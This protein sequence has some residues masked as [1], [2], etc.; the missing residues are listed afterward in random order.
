[1]TTKQEKPVRDLA[2]L[3]LQNL[4]NW[5][6]DAQPT[7]AWACRYLTTIDFERASDYLTW[8]E[9]RDKAQKKYMLWRTRALLVLFGLL[10]LGL[11][12]ASWVFYRLN[13]QAQL[14]RAKAVA[15][16]LTADRQKRLAD[17][18]AKDAQTQKHAAETNAEEAALQRDIAEKNAAAALRTARESKTR[19]LA[20]FSTESLSDDLVKTILLGMQ[21]VKATLRFGQPP[22]A[23]AD[24]A[25]HQATLTSQVRM[26]LRGHSSGVDG[27]AFSP[28]GKRLATASWDHTA[29]VWD[30]ESGKELLT[31]RGHSNGVYGVA[32][33]PD[34]KHLAT[35]SSDHTAKVWDV[36]SGRELLT[37]RGHSDSVDGVA[38]SPDGKRLAT[39]SGDHT[40]K[41]W[42]AGS[43]KE[44]LTLDGHSDVVDGVAFNPDGKRLATASWDHT[45]K[46]WDAE[47]GKELLTLRGHSDRVYG[48]AFS[49]DGKRLA[50]ASSDHTAKVWDV[51]SGKELLTL[52]DHSSGVYGVAYSPDGKRLAT[53]SSDHTAKVWD[54][55]SGKELLTL[56]GHLSGVYGVA[57]SPDGK[58]LATA[59]DDYTAKVW[60]MESGKELLTLRG[61]LSGVYGLA[62]RPDGKRLATASRDGTVQ[63]YAFDLRELLNLARSRLPAP[64]LPRTAH[65]PSSLGPAR[66]CTEQMKREIAKGLRRSQLPRVD[67]SHLE[68]IAV[69]SGFPQPAHSRAP[70]FPAILAI[71][72]LPEAQY[73]RGGTD[74]DRRGADRREATARP[75]NDPEHSYGPGRAGLWRL[76]GEV[77]KRQGVSR[78]NARSEPV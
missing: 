19:E 36:E 74:L 3:T 9:R 49:P 2:G 39:A 35:A 57:F 71:H 1:L 15:S 25:L 44:L 59:S 13:G 46:V 60:D 32:F 73:D 40:A 64:S 26:T 41:V 69:Q 5:R 11:A 31:L 27:V 30:V 12:T 65:A 8:S 29:K 38:Y 68:I 67:E 18:S 28:D 37:L 14:E 72:N 77:S 23:A 17:D 42:D 63:V 43:G 21:T 47:S 34:G 7:A 4:A 53:A 22:V 51:E 70:H 54:A 20:A 56:R 55:E 58:R 48:V 10:V 76:R 61:H 78:G 75:E 45:A 24:K 6:E 52:R 62:F 50:T 66:P 33:S 16:A